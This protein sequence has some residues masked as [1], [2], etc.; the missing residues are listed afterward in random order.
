[1]KEQQ[2]YSDESFRDS[3]GFIGKDG[4]RNYIY[5]KKPKGDFTKYRTYLS[6]GLLVFLFAGP[7]IRIGGQPMLLL[8][9]IGRK[10]VILGQVFWPQDFY[11]LV[12]LLISLVIFVV[13]FTAAFGR[14]FCG[15]VCPQ[16]IFLEMVFR[17]IEYWLDG[18]RGQQLRI[19]NMPWNAEKIRRRLVKWSLFFVISFLI[20]NTFLAYLVGSERVIDMISSNPSANMGTFSALMVFTGIFF[21]V[22]AW[23]REQACIVVCPYG[24]LQGVLLDRNSIVIAYDKIRGEIR[25]RFRKN[26]DREAVGKGDCIDCNQCVVVCPTGIDIR[27]GTQLECVNCT[28]CIDACDEV[29]DKID[30]PRGLIRY[31]S[32]NQISEGEKPKF[33]PRLKFY[34]VVLSILLI[35][36]GGLLF[37][38]STM[39]AN[40]LR[41]PGSKYQVSDDNR[42]TN[43]YQYKI[44]NKSTREQTFTIEA[45][46]FPDAEVKPAGKEMLTAGVQE[47][48]DGILVITIPKDKLTSTNEEIRLVIRG[49]DGEVLGRTKVGF[50]GPMIK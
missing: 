18:D 33:T 20:A 25:S 36:M 17:K 47:F 44:V 10:F 23:F 43:L 26:E 34:T 31:A 4:Q 39:Q 45:D 29:M 3:V 15:W 50:P 32:E 5:P 22:F 30:R 27:N 38:R 35:L 7:F 11:L 21:F 42:I 40:I 9:V 24:R 49:A 2:P 6:W 1:M 14:I 41:L 19:A 12:I 28:A 46:N 16:T 37:S 13:V 48:A 8:D